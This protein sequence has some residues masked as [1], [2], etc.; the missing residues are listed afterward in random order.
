M[1]NWV[2]RIAQAY[3]VSYDAFLKHA[4]GRTGR[5]AR[6]L[7]DITDTEFTRLSAGTG[8]SVERLREMNAAA[9]MR[10]VNEQIQ[11]WLLSESGREALEELRATLGRMARR[12]EAYATADAGRLARQNWDLYGA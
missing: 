7:D 10:R 6:D 8:M 4:L 9:M 3:R 1:E 2:S 12:R 11:G 5:G